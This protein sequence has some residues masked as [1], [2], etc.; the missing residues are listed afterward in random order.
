MRLIEYRRLIPVYSIR[1]AKAQNRCFLCDYISVLA[2]KDTGTGGE[3][4]DTC[5]IPELDGIFY[6]HTGDSMSWGSA[7]LNMTTHTAIEI[8]SAE[9]KG[10]RKCLSNA[11]MHVYGSTAE[12]GDT[13]AH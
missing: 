3:D 7:S 6:L 12:N 2:V 4:K 13:H 8:V 10:L 5:P 1:G 9:E 11:H